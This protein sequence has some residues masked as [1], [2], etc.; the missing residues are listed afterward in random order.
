MLYAMPA[1]VREL[2]DANYVLLKNDLAH[3]SIQLKPIGRLWSIRVGLS[4]RAL[5]VR[6]DQ[7]FVWIWIGL[8]ADYDGM[9]KSK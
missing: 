8:H 1:E 6:D 2:A 5:G 9:I 7:G 4:H 3:P